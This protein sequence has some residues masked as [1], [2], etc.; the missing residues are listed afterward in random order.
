MLAAAAAKTARRVG[1]RRKRSGLSNSGGSERDFGLGSRRNSLR[2]SKSSNDSYKSI[3]SGE[4]RFGSRENLFGGARPKRFKEVIDD[5]AN[6]GKGFFQRQWDNVKGI[7]NKIKNTGKNSY[8]L[9]ANAPSQATGWARK[10]A[11]ESADN[12][13]F[14]GKTMVDDTLDGF[15][16]KVK[17]DLDDFVNGIPGETEIE[18]ALRKAGAETGKWKNLSLKSKASKGLE[19]SGATFAASMLLSDLLPGVASIMEAAKPSDTTPITN[20]YI[21]PDG[22]NYTFGGGHQFIPSNS[23]NASAAPN[24]GGQSANSLMYG[25]SNSSNTQSSYGNTQTNEEVETI[26]PF[27]KVGKGIDYSTASGRKRGYGVAFNISPEMPGGI[28][29]YE[30]RKYLMPTLRTRLNKSGSGVSIESLLKQTGLF[31]R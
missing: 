20:N 6:N 22:P 18:R 8:D 5:A 19:I 28:I 11:K 4:N 21:T 15:R 9:L 7:G 17:N 31:S 13:I 29:N 23:Q 12:V 3:D 27:N 30:N 16:N 10:K 2:S 25:S 24:T 1:K 26:D 14:K